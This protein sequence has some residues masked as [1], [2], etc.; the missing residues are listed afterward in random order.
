MSDFSI[1]PGSIDGLLIIDRK[2]FRDKRGDFC[3]LHISGELDKTVGQPLEFVEDDVSVSRYGVSRGL[4]GDNKTWKLVQ[5]I[6]GDI[7]IAV[8]DVRPTSPTYLKVFTTRLTGDLFHQILI[9]PGCAN[10]HQC[11]SPECIFLYKQTEIYSG[12]Q[13]QFSIHWRDPKLNIPWPLSDP[14][15]SDRD[16]N[17]PFLT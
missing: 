12:A 16:G 11:L 2:V 4:H 1:I 8:A 7:F 15:L 5:C 14:I 6:L 10:G 13:H 17:A 9:P 3:S